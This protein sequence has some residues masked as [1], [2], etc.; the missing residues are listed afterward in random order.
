MWEPESKAMSELSHYGNTHQRHI[1]PMMMKMMMERKMM[2]MEIMIPI[3]DRY[4]HDDY[5]RRDENPCSDIEVH[6]KNVTTPSAYI[7]VVYIRA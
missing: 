5:H 3:T 1:L 6:H 7:H 4:R 2:I